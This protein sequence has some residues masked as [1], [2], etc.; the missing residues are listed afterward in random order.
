[1]GCHR[2]VNTSNSNKV[3]SQT[4][5]LRVI[6]NHLFEVDE[7]DTVEDTIHSKDN[8]I[9]DFLVQNLKIV[10][11]QEAEAITITCNGPQVDPN[12]VVARTTLEV[13]PIHT[14]RRL[15]TRIMVIVTRLAVRKRMYR[16]GHLM[17][18]R[19]MNEEMIICQ[20]HPK[21]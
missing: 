2:R 20:Q 16:L 5:I 18:I 6:N 3:T 9:E 14:R 1:M 8:Q 19:L 7:V 15:H 17:N 11:A 10:P 13:T 4:I 21:P 12:V